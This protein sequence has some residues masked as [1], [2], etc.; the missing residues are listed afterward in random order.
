VY[1]YT[2]RERPLLYWFIK[3]DVPYSDTITTNHPFELVSSEEKYT[4]YMSGAIY[5]NELSRDLFKHLITEEVTKIPPNVTSTFYRAKI[6]D[7][8][9]QLSDFV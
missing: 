9:I 2:A 1:V 7:M 5:D 6:I 8:I 3:C 4:H